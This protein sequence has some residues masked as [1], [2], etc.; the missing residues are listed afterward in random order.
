MPISTEIIAERRSAGIEESGAVIFC[1]NALFYEISVTGD[2]ISR[3]ILF[4]IR[5]AANADV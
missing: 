5:D 3:M 1:S 2:D 4:G